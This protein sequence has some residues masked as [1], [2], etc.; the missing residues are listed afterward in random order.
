MGVLIAPIF[1]K[2]NIVSSLQAPYHKQWWHGKALQA[3][4]K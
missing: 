2:L 1:S 4:E 3:V